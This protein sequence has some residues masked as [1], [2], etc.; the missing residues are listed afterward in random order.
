MLC[1]GIYRLQEQTRQH[2]LCMLYGLVGVI[3]SLTVSC[4]CVAEVIGATADILQLQ[5]VFVE[6]ALITYS[7]WNAC[8]SQWPRGLRRG[9]AAAR[10][11]GLWV[12]IPRGAW[13]SVSCECCVFSGR[14]LCDELVPHPEESYQVWCV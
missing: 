4:L 11:L 8:R 3:R 5:Q 2:H 10:L 13:T 7:Y 9:S 6:P 1:M 12:R 14:C